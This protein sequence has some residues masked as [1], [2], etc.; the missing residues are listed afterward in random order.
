MTLSQDDLK[1]LD[2]ALGTSRVDGSLSGDGAPNGRNFNGALNSLV[3][4]AEQ[5][6]DYGLAYSDLPSDKQTEYDEAH[7]DMQHYLKLLANVFGA[8]LVGADDNIELE[9]GNTVDLP[10]AATSAGSNTA[11]LPDRPN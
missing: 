2:E 6:D 4:I 5:M 10:L 1:N 7:E 9:N 8:D 11:E 3:T